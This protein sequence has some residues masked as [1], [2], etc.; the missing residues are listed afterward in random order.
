[1]TG[2]SGDIDRFFSSERGLPFNYSMQID[3]GRFVTRAL[4]VRGGVRGSGSVGGDD[5]EDLPTGQGV[6][7]C[8][9]SPACST[10]SR[11]SRWRAYTRVL[12]TGRRSRSEIA[13][14]PA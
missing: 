4:V 2:F 14:M 11:P 5:S 3:V 8:K 13:L 1:M 6:P 9:A 7:R 12:T 10:T